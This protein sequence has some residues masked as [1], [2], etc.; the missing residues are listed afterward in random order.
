MR[1]C[2]KWVTSAYISLMLILNFV[3]YIYAEE[4]CNVLCIMVTSETIQAY[5]T[6]SSSP[7]SVKLGTYPCEILSVTPMEEMPS[8]TLILIDTS[9]SIPMDIRQ[10]TKDLIMELIDQKQE[11]E[12]YSIAS[13]GTEINVLCDYT[14]DRYDLAKALEG[15]DYSEK[16]TYVYSVL[17]KVLDNDR[18]D[19][20]RIVMIS[21]GVENSRDGITYDEILNK[22]SSGHCP[23]YTV[24]IENGNQ[25]S[26]KKLYS[27]SR[28]SY[29]ESATLTN[30]SDISQI[31]DTVNSSRNFI[32]V[33]VSVPDEAA[34]GSV[35]YLK[36]SG[37]DYECGADVRIPA[38]E[39]VTTSAVTETE[40]VTT[41]ISET[42]P[43]QNMTD[44]NSGSEKQ[45]H[46]I[47]PLIVSVSAVIAAIVVL[48]KK[49]WGKNK[50]TFSENDSNKNDA[51]TRQ[52][53]IKDDD[54][55]I[56][57]TDVD[58][59]QRS[60]RCAVG[61]GVTIG[62]DSSQCTVALEHDGYISRKHCLIYREGEQFLI[63]NYSPNNVVIN[64]RTVIC[65]SSAEEHSGENTLILLEQSA[66]KAEIMDND[67]IRIGHTRLK[68]N[69]IEDNYNGNKL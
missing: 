49:P 27:F 14:S 21:D 39:A 2:K 10:K 11:N 55:M 50:N 62:R 25:E 33:E 57:L 30:E 58:S 5:I 56:M 63:E 69:I 48:I 16:Y 17:D 8:D 22:I 60:Y 54:V 45:G 59:P 19:F 37:Q 34:D 9:G 40:S 26:L 29:A 53:V 61:N 20:Y 64:D 18:D 41:S 15:L 68:F 3:L 44:L 1:I 66:N 36:I 46:S 35:R 38:K 31:C 6:T 24:G 67:I 65:R 4:V 51:V 42:E 32:C 13:F 23:V 52:D 7:T 12:R 43:Q 47:L 28:N